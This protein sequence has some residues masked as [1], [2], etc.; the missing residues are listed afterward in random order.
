MRTDPIASNQSGLALVLTLLTISFLVALT[1]QLMVTIDRQVSEAT[2]QS[3]QVR[4]D[5]L[6]LAGLNLARA[7]LRADQ[8]ANTAESLLD[9]WADF[10]ADK[11][12][13]LAGGLDLELTVTDLS[14]RLQV[15]ALADPAKDKYRQIWKRFLLSGRFAIADEEAAEALLDALADWVDSDEEELPLGAEEPYYRSLHPPHGCRNGQLVCA[16][17]L[18]LVKGMT[19]ALVYG[20][21]NH[22]GLLDAIT[23]AG[24][25][26]KINLNT[27]PLP[28][29]LAL[30]AEMT[31]KLAED[32]MDYRRD[33]DNKEALATVGWYQQ[34]SGFPSTI[35]FNSD[36]LTVT[37]S[38]FAIKV[39][40]VNGQYQRMGSG[41][42]F[43]AENQEQS[44]LCWKIE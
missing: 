17:E 19:P 42:L 24:D 27:A 10:D 36:I 35:G 25:N 6:V 28:V 40:A 32:L 2:A 5:A 14:G 4:L 16:E 1:L 13:T 33:E 29:L 21:Q 8:Q 37:S 23:V 11:L 15:N 41:I 7:A 26:G 38:F 22:E 20:D 3:E 12:G 43:R 44:L 34:V 31:P 18:L 30:S 39:R 9:S